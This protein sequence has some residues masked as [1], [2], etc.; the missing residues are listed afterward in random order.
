MARQSILLNLNHQVD[1][2]S[3]YP[4]SFS[5]ISEG[6]NFIINSNSS[7]L[8]GINDSLTECIRMVQSVP[9]ETQLIINMI[10]DGK[11]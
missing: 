5:D 11:I 6:N 4:P 3:I 7:M 8:N 9:N 2:K 10:S 1:I